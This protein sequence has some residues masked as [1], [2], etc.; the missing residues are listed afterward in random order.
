MTPRP[1]S[2]IFFEPV[3][4]W[5]AFASSA[6]VVELVWKTLASWHYL[7]F[8]S[9]TS[10]WECP[11][12]GTLVWFAFGEA[13]AITELGAWIDPSDGSVSCSIHSFFE[14]ICVNYGI[15]PRS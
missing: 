9:D 13:D 2:T 15:Q 7:N 11:K 14:E 12:H 4:G 10:A 1:E 8:T 6:D 5:R 3:E